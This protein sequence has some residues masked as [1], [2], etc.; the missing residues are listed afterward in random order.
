MALDKNSTFADVKAQYQDNA[1][2]DIT[3]SVSSARLF[4]EAIRHL[5]GVVRAQRATGVDGG[6]EFE[7]ATLDQEMKDAREYV[8]DNTSIT[9]VGG[10]VIHTDMRSFRD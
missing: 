3:G 8:R 2:Y 10:A 4:I 5:R 9:T 1:G 7:M 6:G